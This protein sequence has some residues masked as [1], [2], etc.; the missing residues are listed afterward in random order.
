MAMTPGRL[1]YFKINSIDLSPWCDTSDY[2]DEADLHETTTY[3]K[4]TKTYAPG[5]KNVSFSVGGLYDAA[6]AAVEP[7]LRPLVGGAATAFE[8]GPEGNAA[9]KKKFTGSALVKNFK[10]SQPVG[11]MVRWS[12][13]VQMTDTVTVAVFP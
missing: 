9:A 2:T 3:G 6:A 1:T 10:T 5:L 8:F 4:S 12:A 11:G 7:T 13:E